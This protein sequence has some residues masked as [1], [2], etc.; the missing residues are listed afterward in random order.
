MKRT[1]WGEADGRVTYVWE[2]RVGEGPSESPA[3]RVALDE[4]CECIIRY[5]RFASFSYACPATLSGAP[6]CAYRVGV[7]ERHECRQG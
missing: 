1:G 4:L 2:A 7:E 3:A 5:L 6:A